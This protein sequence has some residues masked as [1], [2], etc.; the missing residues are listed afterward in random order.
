M[1]TSEAMYLT[2]FDPSHQKGVSALF[3]EIAKE[4]GNDVFSHTTATMTEQSAL[5][6]RH[7]WVT[8]AHGQVIGTVGLIVAGSYSVL[9]SMFVHREYRGQPHLVA[10][11]MLHTAIVK[12]TNACCDNMYL[13]TMHRFTAA[14]RFYGKHGFSRIP[15]ESLPKDFPANAV[16]TVFYCKEL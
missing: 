2:A 11:C 13:G 1:E 12:A 6:G 3:K 5:P 15:P 16:D 7:Y 10:A 14:R 8:V 4:F 9:K